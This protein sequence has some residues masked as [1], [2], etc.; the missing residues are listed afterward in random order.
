MPKVRDGRFF[1]QPGSAEW[2]GHLTMAYPEPWSE[3]VAEFMRSLEEDVYGVQ[4][5]IRELW[6]IFSCWMRKEVLASLRQRWSPC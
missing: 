6:R 3:Q 4:T 2:F 5:Q 1:V